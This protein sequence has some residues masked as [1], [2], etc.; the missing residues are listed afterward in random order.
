M[1]YCYRL[2]ITTSHQIHTRSGIKTITTLTHTQILSSH[3]IWMMLFGRI[4]F[5]LL[6]FRFSNNTIFWNKRSVRICIWLYLLGV[7]EVHI[8]CCCCLFWTLLFW[9]CFGRW[10][11]INFYDAH[12]VWSETEKESKMCILS[13]WHF[14]GAGNVLFVS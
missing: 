7:H 4:F 10:F 9:R 8:F 6:R 3:I 11:H 12:C 1:C 2:T 5:F 13:R 14:G